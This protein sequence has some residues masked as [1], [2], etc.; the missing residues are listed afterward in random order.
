MLLQKRIEELKSTVQAM[1]EESKEI[2]TKRKEV[3]RLVE[4]KIP[5]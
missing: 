3:Q 5:M 2:D 4:V 1:D